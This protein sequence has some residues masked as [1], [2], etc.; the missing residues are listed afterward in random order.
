MCLLQKGAGTA[1]QSTCR[2][3]FSYKHFPPTPGIV[4]R[5]H[6]KPSVFS[7]GT[8]VPSFLDKVNRGIKKKKFC[9]LYSTLLHLPSLKFH[10]VG[11]CWD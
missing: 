6:A 7:E 5:V 3:F 10:C 4:H 1:A 11:G 8:L 9:V 2:I